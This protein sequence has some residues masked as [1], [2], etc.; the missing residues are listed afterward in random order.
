LTFET[1]ILVFLSI[2]VLKVVCLEVLATQMHA[3]WKQHASLRGSL[4]AILKQ[5]HLGFWAA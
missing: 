5:V 1:P 2:Q 3:R 4:K